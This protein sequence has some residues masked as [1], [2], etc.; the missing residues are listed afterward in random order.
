MR[1]GGGA[2]ERWGRISSRRLYGKETGRQISESVKSGTSLLSPG[3]RRTHIEILPACR[4]AGLAATT[5]LTFPLHKPPCTGF[6]HMADPALFQ[7]SIHSVPPSLSLSLLLA[8]DIAGRGDASV[9]W[10]SRP[11]P[12]RISHA[13]RMS[14]MTGTQST[15][16]FQKVSRVIRNLSRF[17][18]LSSGCSSRVA[19]CMRAVFAPP[20][21]CPIV[22]D[23]GRPFCTH[24]VRR[25]QNASSVHANGAHDVHCPPI[26][27]RSPCIPLS[28]Q[29]LRHASRPHRA[30]QGALFS[31]KCITIMIPPLRELS[32]MYCTLT[33]HLSG[34]D[35]R[36]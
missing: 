25:W 23:P 24:N 15:V 10:S 13:A 31:D 7:S 19:A 33:T 1:E 21:N 9:G 26:E 12:C 20:H 35:A 27:T 3:C 18:R 6:C 2:G 14:R 36:K 16:R 30:H 17:G 5:L 4:A 28:L 22:P 11:G 32:S 29:A 8:S 34:L